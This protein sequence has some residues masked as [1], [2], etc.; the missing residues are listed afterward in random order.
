MGVGLLVVALVTLYVNGVQ[1]KYVEENTDQLA[2]ASEKT[3]DVLL[4]EVLP[5]VK[6]LASLRTEV[7]SLKHVLRTATGKFFPIQC[8]PHLFDNPRVCLGLPYA[9]HPAVT[10][11][12][13][14]GMFVLL[15]THTQC[16]NRRTRA[17]PSQPRLT[18]TC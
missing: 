13:I 10:K 8:C 14:K 4:K 9:K 11:D 12:R 15:P 7:A 16:V 1:L 18:L 2:K 3:A 17:H 5:S 6:E